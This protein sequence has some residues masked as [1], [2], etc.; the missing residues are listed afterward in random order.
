MWTA[1]H[2]CG[3]RE[4]VDETGEQQEGQP[5]RLAT[6]TGSQRPGALPKRQRGEKMEKRTN[7][8]VK[9]LCTLFCT[10]HATQTQQ[11]LQ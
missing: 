4:G 6:M 3:R 9:P 1:D 8:A 2:T 10:C 11:P 7:S 5:N